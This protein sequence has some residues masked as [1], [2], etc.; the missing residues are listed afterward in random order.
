MDE[1]PK[2]SR[3]DVLLRE[4]NVTADFLDPE[5]P[6]GY[7]SHSQY[8][9]WKTCGQAYAYRYIDKRRSPGSPATTKGLSVHGGIEFMLMNKKLGKIPPLAEGKEVVSSLF[10][11][12][13]EEVT[14]W[15]EETSGSIKDQ[16]LKVFEH[17]ALHALP[18][19]NPI[20][21]EKG[22]AKKI[23]SVPMIGWIDLIDE[24]PAMIV[25]D[26]P[27]EIQRTAPSKLV[28]V[29]FKTGRAKWSE[30][31]L[32]TDT[33]M[34]LYALVE[35][36]PHVRVDQLISKAKGPEYIRGESF[37]TR[38]DAA[39]LEEDLNEVADFI[40]SGLFPKAQ[41]DSWK[42]NAK[43]CPYWDICRGRKR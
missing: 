14:N 18:R 16:T 26:M 3:T 33:Q 15:Q 28:T 27:E 39:L 8:M 7:F 24:Q 42:C 19:I 36:T 43:M 23:G 5:L 20:A 6:N 41:L 25:A 1:K 13:A 38:Q 9:A 31:E 37:R 30:T 11:K 34:T 12:N 40:R 21:I 22:F 2:E 10:D 32:R 29:D 4:L 35:G 17:F